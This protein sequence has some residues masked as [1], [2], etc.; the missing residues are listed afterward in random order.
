MMPRLLSF[1]LRR[2]VAAAGL[3]TLTALCLAVPARQV[4]LPLWPGAVEELL[5]EVGPEQVDRR[6]RG[7]SLP[8]D[9]AE[10]V[11]ARSRPTMLWRLELA[12]GEVDHVWLA[13]LRNA[14]GQLEPQAPDWFDTVRF[15]GTPPPGSYLVVIGPGYETRELDAARIRRMYRPNA[16][17]PGQRVQ[18]WF[19]R[20]HER[21]RWPVRPAADA[22]MTPPVR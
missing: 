19:D 18:L 9:A 17:S 16:M 13:G 5:V 22:R 10:E 20:L 12:S 1:V 14:A 21:W 3:L 8:L 4:L 11:V 6:F 7:A 15:E 2:S